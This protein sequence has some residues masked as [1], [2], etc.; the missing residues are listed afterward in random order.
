M[1]Y[2]EYPKK[3]ILI[4]QGFTK[5]IDSG[6]NIN[7]IRVSDIAEAA[8]IGKGTVYEYFK[9]KEEIIAKSLLYNLNL[10]IENVITDIEKVSTF[11]EKCYIV[12]QRTMDSKNEKFP[13]LQILR[14]SRELHQIFQ[15]I[16]E[17]LDE[18]KDCRKKILKFM[19]DIINLGIEEKI[20]ISDHDER[21]Q[22][23]VLS[24]V[25]MGISSEFDCQCGT[26]N[27][28]DMEMKKDFA[29]TM[30]VKSLN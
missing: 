27:K 28:E 15:Y 7:H 5:L 26:I 18:I 3:K 30:L 6:A 20:I 9:S 19:K 22:E 8:G 16:N 11:K 21:Y 23:S 2:K 10:E 13:Y 29:Y 17:D 24:S 1:N 14:T 4:F 12:F 25:F